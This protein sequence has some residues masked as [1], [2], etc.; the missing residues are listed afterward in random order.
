MT[1]KDESASDVDA[2]ID[3]PRVRL[4]HPLFSLQ[5]SNTR[6]NESATSQSRSLDSAMTESAIRAGYL[7]ISSRSCAN[8]SF[9]QAGGTRS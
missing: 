5:L 1:A 3:D 2:A 7:P 6:T 9:C 8:D 4:S